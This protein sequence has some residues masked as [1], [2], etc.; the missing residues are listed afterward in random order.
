VNSDP[1][2]ELSQARTF[3][4]AIEPLVRAYRHGIFTFVALLHQGE[5]VLL[6]GQLRLLID[7]PPPV[8]RPIQTTRLSAGQVALAVDATAAEAFL[9]SV[10]A[11]DWLPIG[12][13]L[14]K[15]RP[16]TQLGI[17]PQYS[18][19]HEPA[20]PQHVRDKGAVERFVLSGANCSELIGVQMAEVA[21]ELRELGFAFPEQLFSAYAL[22]GGDETSLEVIASPVARIESDS[23]ISGRKVRVRVCLPRDLPPDRTMSRMCLPRPQ[24]V[25]FCSSNVQLRY[26][27]TVS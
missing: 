2:S 1:L 22:R 3:L 19:Y 18:A 7:A 4:Q 26:P 8:K 10:A 25:I 14:L 24:T 6:R 9:R 27:T 12:N 15:L 23:T 17:A 20:D 21:G 11:G 16:R 13:H 5:K